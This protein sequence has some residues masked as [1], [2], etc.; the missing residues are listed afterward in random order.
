MSES[1]NIT[2]GLY[3]VFDKNEYPNLKFGST[4]PEQIAMGLNVPEDEEW[5]TYGLEDE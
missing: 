2:E 4:T 1:T 3:P 5:L